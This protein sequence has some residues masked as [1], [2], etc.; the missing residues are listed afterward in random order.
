MGASELPLRS[1]EDERWLPSQVA[2]SDEDELAALISHEGTGWAAML[3]RLEAPGDRPS[4]ASGLVPRL[5]RPSP[6]SIALPLV[7]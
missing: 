2:G 6:F 5:L 1:P 3:D 7:Q 4:L